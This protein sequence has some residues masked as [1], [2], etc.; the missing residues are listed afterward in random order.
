[1]EA[2]WTD[3]STSHSNVHFSGS[4]QMG[5]RSTPIEW[6]MEST[7]VFKGADCGSV[8]PIGPGAGQ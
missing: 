2:T 8:K 3:A 1:V 6:T 4:M 5:P 7:S